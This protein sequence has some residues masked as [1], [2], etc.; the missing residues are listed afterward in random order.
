V[1]FL[2]FG[3]DIDKEIWSRDRNR[4][5]YW[6][7]NGLSRGRSSSPGRAKNFHF[8]TSSV[9]ALGPTQSLIDWI[10]GTLSLGI[11]RPGREA[12]HSPPTGVEGMLPFYLYRQIN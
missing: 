12:D 7:R 10:P 5:N 9:P 2:Y 1:I 11:K 4:Y 6:L 3:G 8:S